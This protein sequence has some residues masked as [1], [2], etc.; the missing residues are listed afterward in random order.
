MNI[1]ADIPIYQ[2][3]PIKIIEVPE[4]GR[5][6]RQRLFDNYDATCPPAAKKID[7]A[8]GWRPCHLLSL[9]L[10]NIMSRAIIDAGCFVGGTTHAL[11]EGLKNNTFIRPEDKDEGYIRQWLQDIFGDEVNDEL[12]SFRIFLTK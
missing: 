8:H 12:T 7:H 4:L 2:H 10:A 3:V 5:I 11:I 9:R 1:G 6:E